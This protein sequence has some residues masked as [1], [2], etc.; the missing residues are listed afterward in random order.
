MELAKEDERPEVRMTTA[1]KDAINR[2]SRLLVRRSTL[3][4][5]LTSRVTLR[6]VHNDAAEELMLL[7]E[8]AAGRVQY[9]VGDAFFFDSGEEVEARIE[10]V[11]ERLAVEIE[12]V[13][14]EITETEQEIAELK[15]RLYAKF[16]NTIN[17][18]E[19]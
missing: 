11:R 12:D 13:K 9:N 18:E 8:D 7:D 5:K 19:S 3:Q 17:L 2:F 10:E 6:D 14:A 1:D 15:S 4:S 16:G